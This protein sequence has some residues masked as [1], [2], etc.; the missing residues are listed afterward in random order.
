[1]PDDNQDNNDDVSSFED[2]AIVNILLALCQY[3]IIN[4]VMLAF[5]WWLIKPLFK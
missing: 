1:M 2:D 3:I 4:A 5:I